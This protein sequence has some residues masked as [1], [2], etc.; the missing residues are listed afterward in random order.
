MAR[1]RIR[2]H[3][4]FVHP[5]AK[6]LHAERRKR[7]LTL[8]DMVGI[9]GFGEEAVGQ[10]ERGEAMPRSIERLEKWCNCLGYE[11]VIRKKDKEMERLSAIVEGM[12]EHA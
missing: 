12:P 11:L 2:T 5:I 10:W 8:E 4:R 6:M 7:K 1:G 3:K 9:T